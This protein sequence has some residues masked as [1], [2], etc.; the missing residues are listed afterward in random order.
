LSRS[1]ACSASAGRLCGVAAATVADDLAL[2]SEGWLETA[3]FPI[4]LVQAKIAN[5]GVMLTKT[6][7]LWWSIIASTGIG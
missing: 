4:W 1:I 5:I 2:D 7:N 3:L 6:E